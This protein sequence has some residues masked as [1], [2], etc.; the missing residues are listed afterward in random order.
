LVFILNYAD[1]K[2]YIIYED[3]NISSS[4]NPVGSG[5]R[6]LGMGG[7]FIAVSDDATAASWNPSGLIQL[8]RPELSVVGAYASVDQRFSTPSGTDI[9]NHYTD[10]FASLNYL[11][12]TYP[13]N[14]LNR[15]MVVSV[16]YQRLYEFNLNFGYRFNATIPLEPP[17]VS[18]ETSQEIDYQQD[19]Y[20]G[21][22]G[23][24][25][26][27]ELTPRVSVGVTINIWSDTLGL[28]NGWQE[29]LSVNSQTVITNTLGPPETTLSDVQ[30][31]NEYSEFNGLNANIGLLWDLNEHLTLGAV[32]KTPFTG[33]L[34]RRSSR[35]DRA[36]SLE[37][38]LELDMPMSYGIGLAYR[39]SDRFTID[40]DAYRTEWSKYLL[41]DAE[42]NT[43][44]PIDGKP[45]NE[46]D[47]EDTTQ[48]RMGAEYL[49]LKPV[50]D[51]V[52][53]MRAGLFYD[54][55]PSEGSQKEFYGIS[56][57]TGLGYKQFIFDL[58][59]Q[60][61]WGRGVDTESLIIGSEADVRQHTILFSA[62][63]H[64]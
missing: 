9:K 21:A 34:K 20:L 16:N 59:Y 6:A 35:N 43:F 32:L 25:Y 63:Y 58:A 48:I 18:V 12:A 47:I 10:D 3:I 30:I 19:G 22:L 17:F 23:L 15:N 11:S 61:R 40:L 31:E 64:F 7:A 14:L 50:T 37:D 29:T 8:E 46:S 57:G 53:P 36:E 27:L 49:I 4:P 2:A 54:P 55:E 44:S 51:T 39:F 1:V 56:L 60:L 42:G 26:A 33:S 5:A 13:F 24:A 41:T 45:E 38:D 28:K 52:I 62:I